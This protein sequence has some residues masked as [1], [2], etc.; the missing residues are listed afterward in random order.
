MKKRR[1]IAIT[2][3]VLIV[4]IFSVNYLATPTSADERAM[5][6]RIAKAINSI[7]DA[8]AYLRAAPHDFGGHR[9]EAIADCER[10]VRQLNLALQYRAMQD[11]KR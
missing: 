7:E 8:V 2:L 6:P 4:S 3:A 10:A 5:H 9:A 11:R 1:F